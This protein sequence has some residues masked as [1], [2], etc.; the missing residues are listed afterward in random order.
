MKLLSGYF[1]L[2]VASCNA[3]SVPPL[4]PSA[5]A[6]R[7]MQI[8]EIVPSTTTLTTST[9]PLSSSNLI[10]V[11]SVTPTPSTSGPPLLITDINFDG[12]VPT[13][14]ADEYVVLTNPRPTPL[15]LSGYYLYVATNGSQG[16]TFT[17]P[18]NSPTLKPNASIRIYTN[19]IHPESGGYSFGS[20]K[21]L[22][23][24]KG[25]L[26]VLKDSNGKKLGEFKYP[27]KA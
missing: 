17:F 5:P 8:R 18:K 6:T 3:F 10:A 16:A 19:E 4:P 14:E 20:G 27:A 24:N 9:S 11:A 23:N 2:M 15:D 1:G 22:W 12:K 25:G 21:A 26:A 13:T 7:P